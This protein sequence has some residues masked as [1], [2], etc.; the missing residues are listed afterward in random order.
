MKQKRWGRGEEGRR[1]LENFRP[2]PAPIV[3]FFVLGLAFAW[4]NYFM[5]LSM[6]CPRM[7]KGEGMG[8]WATHGKFDIFRF[9]MSISPPLSFHYESNLCPFCELRNRS[10]FVAGGGGEAID[11]FGGGIT[12]FLR[13]Q[14]GGIS[15][16]CQA[17]REEQEKRRKLF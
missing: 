11:F 12:R 9:Q 5:H 16:N 13:E 15:L 1:Q 17:L 3:F 14:R 10:L 8:W 6:V 4:L 2:P 7:G